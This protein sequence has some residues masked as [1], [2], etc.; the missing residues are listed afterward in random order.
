MDSHQSNVNFTD[1]PEDIWLEIIKICE[2]D[3]LYSIYLVNKLFQ[4]RI[5]NKKLLPFRI[6]LVMDPTTCKYGRQNLEN[7]TIDFLSHHK[8]LQKTN[9]YELKFLEYI[10]FDKRFNNPQLNPMI[11]MLEIDIKIF[12]PISEYRSRL[13]RV[14][15]IPKIRMLSLVNIETIPWKF[16][17]IF[18]KNSF[19]RYL[20]LRNGILSS[21]MDFST[22]SFVKFNL[23]N[24]N[25][26]NDTYIKMPYCLKECDLNCY[27]TKVGILSNCFI[28]FQMSHCKE[29]NTL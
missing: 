19:W 13:E 14:F 10:E 18:S 17:Q 3:S 21:F 5:K 4:Q 16:T 20:N 7:S 24:V 29:L 11:N 28:K 1:L 22:C 12:H 8:F 6:C 9:H 27:Q 2:P 26:Q 15:Y 23:D 25:C